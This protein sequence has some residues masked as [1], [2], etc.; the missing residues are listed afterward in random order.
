MPKH[1]TE[2]GLDEAQ[3]ARIEADFAVPVDDLFGPMRSSWISALAK[4][5]LLPDD[6]ELRL[7]RH[8]TEW[9]VNDRFIEH[10]AR[11]ILSMPLAADGG[12]N[13]TTFYKDEDGWHARHSTWREGFPYWPAMFM[14][15]RAPGGT[16]VEVIEHVLLG[17]ES[18]GRRATDW[19]AHKAANPALFNQPS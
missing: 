14:E 4:E 3:I 1:W 16:L 17:V 12:H 6:A 19:D 7:I 9:Y 15:G 2:G 18:G 10:Y 13:T 11:R 8:A 5:S